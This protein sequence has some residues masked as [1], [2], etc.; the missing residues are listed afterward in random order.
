LGQVVF[1]REKHTITFPAS[2]NMAEGVVEYAVVHVTGKVHESVLRTEVDPYYIQLAKLF[3]SPAG[4]QTAAEP[5]QPRD[6]IGAPVRLYVG[7]TQAG[8]A[9]KA[10][11]EELIVN[12]LTVSPMKSGPWVYNGSRV[13]EGV[14]LAQRDGSIVTI[15]ADPDAMVNNPRP[16]R[17]DDE[18]WRVNQNLTPPVGTPVEVTIEL[19]A[20]GDK[21]ER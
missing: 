18:I 19:E 3:I 21:T 16:G 9:R 13:V 4:E 14:F 7:W 10:P 20:Q 6:L 8:T 12:T 5:G 11:L 2:V 17:N 1:D 15:I